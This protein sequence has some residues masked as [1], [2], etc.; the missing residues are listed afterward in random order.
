MDGSVPPPPLTKHCSHCG[1][2]RPRAMFVHADGV[3]TYGTCATCRQRQREL[4]AGSPSMSHGRPPKMEELPATSH[5]WTLLPAR[6]FLGRTGGKYGWCVRATCECGYTRAHLVW[7]WKSGKTSSCCRRCAAQLQWDGIR[8]RAEKPP[9]RPR[10]A[11]SPEHLQ[12][13][14]TRW[15]DDPEAQAMVA[16]SPGGMTLGEVG[17]YFGITRERVRQ[18]EADALRKIRLADINTG[19]LRRAL[20]DILQDRPGP[21]GLRNGPSW[22]E[23]PSLG[24]RE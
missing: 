10:P 15:A 12:R 14:R 3:R 5:R 4:R 20:T 22:D 8:A 23:I 19:K 17:E 7:A 16:E 1:N 9:R 6:A 2:E 13:E 24:L 21:T 18:I 11:R